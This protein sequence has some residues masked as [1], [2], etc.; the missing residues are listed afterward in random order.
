MMMLP[1]H[2][3]LITRCRFHADRTSVDLHIPPVLV[4][5]APKPPLPP[6]NGLVVAAV[7][8]KPVLDVLDPKPPDAKI[9]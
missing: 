5:L 4:E 3:V 9:N 8:P 2:A 6:P 7:L 1:D